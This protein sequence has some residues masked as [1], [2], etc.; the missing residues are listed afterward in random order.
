[1]VIIKPSNKGRLILH[2]KLKTEATD[3]SGGLVL[4]YY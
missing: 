1:M 4:I 2:Q 3:L